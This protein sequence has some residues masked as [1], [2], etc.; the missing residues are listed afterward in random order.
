MSSLVCDTVARHILERTPARF[1]PLVIPSLVRSRDLGT[2]PLPCRAL[3]RLAPPACVVVAAK[4]KSVTPLAAF[5]LTTAVTVPAPLR[6]GARSPGLRFFVY[7]RADT[8]KD[9]R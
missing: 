1:K 9:F 6:V 7:R 4:A 5:G 3:G 2:S 8:A